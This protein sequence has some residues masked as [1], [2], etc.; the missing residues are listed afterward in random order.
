MSIELVIKKSVISDARVFTDA[1]DPGFSG[2]VAAALTGR[3]FDRREMM[4]GVL[5]AEIEKDIRS[6]LLRM[7]EESEL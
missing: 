4:S 2:A 3:G 6:D 5:Q 7:I 1:M